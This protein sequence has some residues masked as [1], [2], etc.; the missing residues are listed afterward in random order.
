MSGGSFRG[1]TPGP[2]GRP[3]SAFRQIPVLLLSAG[4][5]NRNKNHE[6]VIRA[7]SL[8]PKRTFAMGSADRG[9]GRGRLEELIEREGLSERVRLLGY[10]KDIEDVLPAA[11]CFL[12]PSKREGFGMAAVEAMAAGLPSSP[13]TAGAPEN[14]CGT[15]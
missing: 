12:F 13:P 6:T 5:L 11:D 2:P 9:D 10:R 8:L 1:R 7:L 15:E 4:E 3:R 14:T